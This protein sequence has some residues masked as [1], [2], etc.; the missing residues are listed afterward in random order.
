MTAVRGRITQGRER[1]ARHPRYPH[2]VLGAALFGIFATNVNVSVLAVVIPRLV[3][4]FDSTKTVATWVVT[5]PLLAFAVLGPTA[6]KLGDLYG[7]RT[8][9]LVGLGGTV[10]F[11]GLTAAAPSMGSL[12]ALRTIGATFGASCGPA[13]MAIISQLF[14]RDQ[15]VKVLGYWG[16]VIA[17]GPVLGMVVGGPLADAAGWRWLFIPQV[18]FALLALA[19][20][21]VVL[22][23]TRAPGRVRLDVVGSVLLV[24]TVGSFLLGVNRGPVWGWTDGRV[25]GLLAAAP[26]GALGFVLFE[27]RTAHPLI[28]LPYFGRRNFAMPMLGQFFV[29]VAYQGGFVLLPLMLAEVYGYTST[30]IS[31]V[32]LA[33]P[34]FYGL[35][36][37]VAGTAAMRFGE[38][39]MAASGAA[40][41]ALSS[42]LLAVVG[43]G[44]V[45]LMVFTA[46][47]VAGTG[48]GTLVP[49]MT[50][51]MT[52]AV[53][54][55]DL[56]VAGAAA[57]TVMQIGTVT[58]MQV[59]QSIQVANQPAMGLKGSYGVA[60]GVG[61]VVAL[62]A[63]VLATLIRSTARP[64]PV[65]A[66]PQRGV[67]PGAALGARQPT[68]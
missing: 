7:R 51:T 46:L 34:L 59:L 54:D 39:R 21:F 64:R 2:L 15:R 31:L 49:S 67:A 22:P 3:D 20:A 9:Y 48:L 6:G 57:Q 43:A 62:V 38:R 1:V 8:I 47:A 13:G 19:V 17:G 4:D 16:L 36:G 27:G 60:F 10:I 28:P 68:T 65:G 63:T 53:S 14:P 66:E 41:V 25:V 44:P 61:A 24:L 58:G 32:T 50:A 56:G 40:M 30:R 12:I 18:P 11:A 26:V 55:A 42:L 37:P 29:N 5:A 45:D 35:A 23:E 33:R 52:T